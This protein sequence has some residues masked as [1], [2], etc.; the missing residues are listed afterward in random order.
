MTN[1][2]LA[3]SSSLRAVDAR[4][5]PLVKVASGGMATVFVG[6]LR[7]P[8]GFSQLVAIKRPHEHLLE[9]Q[10]FRH[11]LIEEARVAAQIRHANVVDVRDIEVVGD[12]I[13]LI[14]DYVEG[15]SLGQLMAVAGRAGTRLSR[16]VVIRI[17]LDA[18][19]GL[20]AVH[21][22]ADGDGIPLGLVHRD[23]SPQN[24]LVG[25]DGVTRVT[26][27]GIAMAEYGASTPTTQ[28]TLKG[29]IGYMA[30]EYIRGIRPDA[31]VD[32]F[33]MGVVLWEALAGRRLFKGLNDADAFDRL[34]HHEPPRLST[35]V[36]ELEGLLDEVLARALAKAP[37]KRF[38]TANS[39][40]TALE[41]A[42]R[43]I[44]LIASHAEV[45]RE[46]RDTV[47]EKL[48]KRRQ[49]VRAAQVA[50]ESVE[51][52]DDLQL[53]EDEGTTRKYEP[54]KRPP[55]A[56]PRAM[57]TAISAPSLASA[58]A[59][60][61]RSRRVVMIMLAALGLTFLLIIFVVS[62]SKPGPSIAAPIDSALP[63]LIESSLPTDP[64]TNTEGPTITPP[65]ANE[66]APSATTTT[67]TTNGTAAI[68]P[69][70]T[71]SPKAT[72]TAATTT[73]TTT[74]TKTRKLPPN[75]YGP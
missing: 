18:L 26:D 40:A 41:E 27:F 58:P 53:L 12:S 21:E 35:E 75:P 25:V 9:D 51:P 23:I 59:P 5:V 70:K 71:S 3:S 15:A 61:N 47:G 55:S 10:S 67:S 14:M 38:Q 45:G 72:T 1:L 13:Q 34:L 65:T 30:P 24:I 39:F 74:K 60:S 16:G 32:V 52:D 69:A 4:Y 42:A 22:V 68:A 20:S 49:D 66:A 46:V 54:A 62:S 31:R 36:P 2:L 63:V 33:A 7:G 37:E 29:K 57:N 73:T 64:K 48:E 17:V 50:L 11:S 56:A 8:L 6:T 28:G 43:T 19:A 44:G